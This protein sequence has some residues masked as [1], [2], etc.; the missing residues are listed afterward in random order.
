MLYKHINLIYIVKNELHG[1]S[2]VIPTVIYLPFSL[3]LSVPAPI[4]Y[5][6]SPHCYC[7]LLPEKEDDYFPFCRNFPTIQETR[8]AI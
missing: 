3:L 8:I 5:K 2:H 6:I 4:P 7:V 1:K